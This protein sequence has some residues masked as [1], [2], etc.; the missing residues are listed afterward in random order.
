MSLFAFLLLEIKAHAGTLQ[1][2]I[3]LKAKRQKHEICACLLHEVE[4][5]KMVI[6]HGTMLF[7]S[8]AHS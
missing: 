2:T 6:L 3:F 5:F 8:S 7:Q 4:L 1:I